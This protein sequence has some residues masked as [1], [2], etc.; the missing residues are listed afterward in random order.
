MT[1]DEEMARIVVIFSFSIVFYY[2]VGY[3]IHRLCTKVEE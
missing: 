2:A 3:S 1:C